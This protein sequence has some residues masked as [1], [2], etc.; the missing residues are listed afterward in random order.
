MMKINSNSISSKLI[1]A[2]ALLLAPCMTVL[3]GTRNYVFVDDD[4][5]FSPENY[6][7]GIYEKVEQTG[8]T[9][10]ITDIDVVV[11]GEFSR[12]NNYYKKV[13]DASRDDWSGTYLLAGQTTNT[14]NPTT[15]Y[16]YTGANYN[17][18]GYNT[19]ATTLINVSESIITNPVGVVE[20]IIEQIISGYYSIGFV[21]ENETYY[22]GNTST[23]SLSNAITTTKP[24]SSDNAYLWSITPQAYNSSYN[25]GSVKISNKN[26]TATILSFRY[27]ASYKTFSGINNTS[28][29]YTTDGYSYPKLYQ[30]AYKISLGDLT[31]GTAEVDKEYAAEGETVT[32][33]THPTIG[34]AT[35]GVSTIPS[36]TITGDVTTTNTFTFTMP[37]SDVEVTATFG[38]GSSSTYHTITC[39]PSSAEPANGYI[40]ANQATAAPGSIVKITDT[41]ADG[42]Q[43]RSLS[44]TPEGG[45]ATVID[46]LETKQF[47]MPSS[48]V[49]VTGTFGHLYVKETNSPHD[50]W[51][52]EYIIGFHNANG[53]AGLNSTN[54]SQNN[55]QATDIILSQYNDTILLPNTSRVFRIE[56]G[57]KWTSDDFPSGNVNEPF[58]D[59]AYYYIYYINGGNK[60][61][62]GASSG[63][64]AYTNLSGTPG[65]SYK[66]TLYRNSNGQFLMRNFGGKYYLQ[67]RFYVNGSTISRYANF[68]TVSD[69]NITTGPSL[70]GDWAYPYVYKWAA[71][72]SDINVNIIGDGSLEIGG[73]ALQSSSNKIAYAGRSVSLS[74]TPGTSCSLHSISVTDEEGH[75]IALTGGSTGDYQFTMPASAVTVIVKF[76]PSDCEDKGVTRNASNAITNAGTVASATGAAAKMPYTMGAK[77]SY[78]QFL[79]SGSDLPKVISSIGFMYYTDNTTGN[80]VK[81]PNVTIYMG[82]TDATELTDW[83]DIRNLNKVYEG[84]LNFYY[85][86]GAPSDDNWSDFIFNCN[87]GKFEH[88]PN[89][90]LVVTIHNHSGLTF[91]GTSNRGFYWGTGS[92][93]THLY[94]GSDTQ[95]E[96][97]EDDGKPYL[98]GGT[99]PLNTNN[100]AATFPITH[101]CGL[102]TYTV[103]CDTEIENGEISASPN[104]NL[105]GGETITITAVPETG[106]TLSTVTATNATTS[107]AITLSGSGNTR[108]FIMPEADVTV[109]ATFTSSAAPATWVDAVTSQPTSYVV[110]GS[111]NVTISSAEGLAWLISV[112]NGGESLSGKT[113]SLDADLDMDDH[114]WV[115][116]GYSSSKPFAGTFNGNYH[117]IKGIHIEDATEIGYVETAT[118][119]DMLYTGLFGYT[120][121]ATIKNTFVLSGQLANN[122]A[123]GYL[124]GLVGYAN[125][126]AIE[127]CETAD[128]LK[129]L[130]NL[131]A[132][133]GMIGGAA[134]GT[135]AKGV[136]VMGNIDLGTE[137]ANAGAVIGVGAAP[138]T[139]FTN[140]T[141]TGDATTKNVAGTN[142]YIRVSNANFDATAAYKPGNGEGQYSAPVAYQ[143][144]DYTTNNAVNGKPLYETLN[145]NLNNGF[146]W[147]RPKGSLNI[148]GGYPFIARKNNDAILAV[149]NKGNEKPVYYGEANSIMGN[150]QLG[151]QNTTDIYIYSNGII[152]TTP[153]EA[154]LFIDE[155]ASIKQPEGAKEELTIAATVGITMDNSANNGEKDRDWHTF[156]SS[157]TAGQIGIGYNGSQPTIDVNNV[158]VE[159]A[160]PTDYWLVQNSAVYFPSGIPTTNN[161]TEFDIYSFYEPQYHWIN[162]KRAGNNHW[163]EDGGAHIDYNGG[164]SAN[165]NETIYTP[166]KGYL[167]A[168][169]DNSN[170]KKVYMSATGTLQNGDENEE[171][172]VTVTNS[173]D[174]L[175]GYNLLGNPYQSYLDF[176][177]FAKVNENIIWGNDHSK[178]YLAYLIYDADRDGFDEYLFTYTDGG[179]QHVGQSFSQGS[180]QTASR[181][182][183][184]HQG[185]FVVKKTADDASHKEVVFNNDMRSITETSSF[186]DEVKPAYPLV[187]LV[188]TDDNGK[189]EISV[190]EFERPSMA[191]SLRMKNMLGAKGN[192]YIRWE[193]EDF[194]NV[195]LTGTPEYVPVWFKAVEAGV[196]TMTW[197]TANGDFSTLRLIDNLTGANIDM[198]TTDSYSFE[199]KPSDSKARFRLV[200]SALGIE[201]ETT[202]YNGNFA[203]FNGNE[204]VVN[205]EGELSLIDLNGRVLNMQHLSGQQSHIAMPKVASGMYML[206]LANA[207]G[208]RVQKIVIRK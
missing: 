63:T 126:S 11:K 42:F 49:T 130:A 26:R 165:T 198:L 137:V 183:H 205:G 122:R 54:V 46:H 204:L 64:P 66:W 13:T 67:C 34:Y 52:G 171:V 207:D 5:Q 197:S 145:E 98:A 9:S 85:K 129:A 29:H 72:L 159:L 55:F 136:M 80:I 77:N 23:S 187:N 190:I 51:A 124:G 101:F 120:N 208:V 19:N 138:E 156:A 169:G 7:Y 36:C 196:F 39:V 167:I 132:V 88:N 128:T 172:K 56:Y 131:A 87:D 27:S 200:F 57:G 96:I 4:P 178:G 147:I 103:T 59:S 149:A 202:E 62:M 127:M 86:A 95:I 185:F 53:K 99:T 94:Y 89:K 44:Y 176:Q 38:E 92:A 28:S 105:I 108:T 76:S 30:R 112:V 113:V 58:V 133:G 31:N 158:P 75:S 65:N 21:Y 110:D 37:A 70:T 151:G 181:Y 79:Y 25:M 148:N 109:T 142:G 73:E 193:G 10:A 78:K 153:S 182:I 199:A 115:P 2:L 195:F 140:H 102:P 35:T 194:G 139:F 22:V 179:E 81:A 24:T 106:Y 41:P 84:P 191:G 1:L 144:G 174:H 154:S 170:A 203:F 91:E 173:G 118:G 71:P 93:N 16:I 61:Y 134:D 33:T 104:S 161:G 82:D 135:T 90:N 48:N 97:H 47:Y 74:P 60:F 189:R 20:V 146:Q 166:G 68:N 192:M 141:I 17:N 162:L 155:H 150:A 119:D 83:V 177:E 43:L 100:K 184:P 164:G 163:H 8:V 107:E 123:S 143:Y 186:R 18:Y 160:F 12:D 111:G 6:Y 3:S 121:G 32:L 117:T 168:I 45:S 175:T 157:L 14:T 69:A 15:T 180:L 116:I 50:E 201:E 125:N 206:R 40:T 114:I 152:T 188:C